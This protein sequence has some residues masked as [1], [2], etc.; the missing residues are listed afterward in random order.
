[1]KHFKSTNQEYLGKLYTAIFSSAYYGLLRIGE[2]AKGSHPILAKDVQIGLNKKKILFI[3]RTSKT[4]WKD[5]KPQLIKITGS[6]RHKPA[7][8]DPNLCPFLYTEKI[9]SSP[10]VKQ[11]RS[12]TILRI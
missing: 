12:R 3:L 2:I 7:R 8:T 6:S 4:H 9:H 1:M 5:S 10:S 11:K